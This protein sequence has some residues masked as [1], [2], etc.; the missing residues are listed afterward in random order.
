MIIKSSKHNITEITNSSKLIMLDELFIDYKHDLE[1]YINYIIDDVLPLKPNLSSKLLPTE[2][3]KHSR[4]KQ[5]IYK[6]ASEIIRSQID[7]CNKKRYNNYKKVYSYMMKN[8]PDSKFVKT[9]YSDLN[10]KSVLKSKYF[11]KPNLNNISIN[12]DERFFNLQNG[13]HFDTFVNLKLP[14]FNDK[15]TRSLQI[16]IPLKHHKHSNNLKSEEF[17][18]RNNIQIK[19]VKDKY[20]INLIWFK[21][22]PEKKTEGVSLGMDMG[23]KKLIVTS[24][25]QFLN[26]NLTEIYNKIS[27]KKQGSKAF[28]KS[29]LHRDNEIN[30][31][32]NNLPL[33]DVKNIIIEDLKDVKKGK[34]YFNNKIQR[35]TYVKTIDKI[36][37]ICE[38]KGINMVKVSPAYTSQTCSKCGH[39]DKNSRNKE[40]FLCVG[41]GYETD[42][43]YNASINI[44]N[45]GVY[46][47][48][49]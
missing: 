7:K 5:I 47:L 13:K 8:H 23:Y 36:N 27:K 15:G 6:K 43:D 2:N 33:D 22:L 17:N 28:K 38:V 10:L 26:G 49:N 40:E 39:I 44:Y 12:L 21:T 14:Y 29:L 37:R 32:C 34:K 24:N 46:S 20:F 3:L 31:I 19:K 41:C 16:N 11:T 1:I 42:A 18:L 48:S 25:K 9:K 45:R 30:R 4:Y 35:W